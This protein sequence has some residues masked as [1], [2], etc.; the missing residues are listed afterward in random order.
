MPNPREIAA[1]DQAFSHLADELPPQLF[2]FFQALVET[3]FTQAEALE[4]TKAYLAAIL[5]PDRGSG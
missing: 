4:L 2:R 1:A 5:A 3:G